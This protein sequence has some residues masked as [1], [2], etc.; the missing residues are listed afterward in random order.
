MIAGAD[1][2]H[3]EQIGLSGTCRRITKERFA[4]KNLPRT[5]L[6]A[7]ALAAFPVAAQ[8]KG[9]IKGAIVGAVAGHYAGHTKTGAVAGC[10]I[11]HSRAAKRERMREGY[12]QP[13]M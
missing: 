6:L 4:M 9:C 5:A 8:A 12:V 2:A 10:I 7:V 3:L 1:A 13:Q 11:G